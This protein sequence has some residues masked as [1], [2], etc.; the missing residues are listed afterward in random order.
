M[1]AQ[2]HI[3]KSGKTITGAWQPAEVTRMRA[4]YISRLGE[5][6]HGTGTSTSGPSSVTVTDPLGGEDDGCGS[7]TWLLDA[8]LTPVVELLGAW[9][10]C[11]R[12]FA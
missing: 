7:N 8:A 12:C 1:C 4:G 2:L 11:C 9:L 5:A 3:E 10:T 6:I